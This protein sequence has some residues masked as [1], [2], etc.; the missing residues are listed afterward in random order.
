MTTKKPV[1]EKIFVKILM[2]FCFW[3]SVGISFPLISIISHGMNI[4]EKLDDNKVIYFFEYFNSTQTY[5]IIVGVILFYFIL[6]LAISIANSIRF[7]LNNFRSQQATMTTVNKVTRQAA[8]ELCSQ[9]LS[10][11]S[12]ILTINFL[13]FLASK[14]MHM[15]IEFLKLP[16]ICLGITFWIIFIALLIYLELNEENSP[17][18]SPHI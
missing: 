11:G 7:I 6:L 17:N 14:I 12:V 16:S 2:N 4:I 5:G 8:K 3:L 1:L 10:I 18:K 9:L 13:G 15:N